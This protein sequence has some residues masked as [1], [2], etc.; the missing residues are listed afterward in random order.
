LE[1]VARYY[2]G[3]F[4]N[5]RMNGKDETGELLRL[6]SQSRTIAARALRKILAAC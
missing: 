5:V 4:T 3:M 1:I 6:G 2:F